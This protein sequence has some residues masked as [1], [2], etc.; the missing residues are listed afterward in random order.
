MPSTGPCPLAPWHQ[1]RSHGRGH[2]CCCSGP[3]EAPGHSGLRRTGAPQLVRPCPRRLCARG[4]V[5]LTFHFEAQ[6]E[7]HGQGRPRG[8][9]AL[10][11]ARLLPRHRLPAGGARADRL[12]LRRLLRLRDGGRLRH[13]R[14]HLHLRRAGDPP[15]RGPVVRGAQ[16]RRR[17]DRAGCRGPLRQA[18]DAHDAEDRLGRHAAPLRRRRAPRLLAEGAGA[19][20]RR[21]EVSA[22]Q[23]GRAVE[24]GERRARVHDALRVQGRAL[25]HLERPDEDRRVRPLLRP[26]HLDRG[27]KV[28]QREAD[29]RAE[30]HDGGEA[31]RGRGRGAR[32]RHRGGRHGVA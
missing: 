30:A 3:S 13:R 22:A 1:Q 27:D 17:G 26:R 16:P 18:R 5:P 23:E 20:G 15:G 19:H 21:R 2:T 32:G 7:L 12:L 6:G 9:R 14:P 10:R 11:A 28:Q 25:H 31:R 29:R 4:T 8:R 24:G